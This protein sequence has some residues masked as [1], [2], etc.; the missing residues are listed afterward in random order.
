[1]EKLIK[2]PN[3]KP[4]HTKTTVSGQQVRR[5]IVYVN[6][7][8]IVNQHLL[9]VISK[10]G[11]ILKSTFQTNDLAYMKPIISIALKFSSQS[12]KIPPTAVCRRLIKNTTK[13]KVKL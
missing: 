2:S 4:V 3:A 7:V 8:N 11:P 10:K 12:N 6:Y 9:L 5:N 1:M 13:I